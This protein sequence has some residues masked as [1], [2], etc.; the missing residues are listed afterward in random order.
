VFHPACHDIQPFEEL[1]LPQI[2]VSIVLNL[3]SLEIPFGL[4]NGPM[5]DSVSVPKSPFAPGIRWSIAR[6]PSHSQPLTPPYV[7]TVISITPVSGTRA[8][9]CCQEDK[10]VSLWNQD[11]SLEKGALDMPTNRPF[12]MRASDEWWKGVDDWRRLQPDMP[13]RAEAIRR[14]VT[15]GLRADP[16]TQRLAP[17][18]GKAKE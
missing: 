18:K 9:P 3:A 15:I 7:L 14:L 11:E 13:N 17:I 2:S 12:Q 1:G 16:P 6:R 8:L 10:T 4:L 5:F